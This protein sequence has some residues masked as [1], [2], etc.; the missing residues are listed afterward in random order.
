M[1]TPSLGEQEMELLHFMVQHEPMSV[2]DAV[3][4]FGA[5]R[6]L[7]RTTVL[8][9]MER[10]RKKGYLARND[11]GRVYLYSPSQPRKD[12]LARAVKGFVDKALGGSVS[13]IVAYLSREAQLS[14][15]DLEELRKLVHELE[16]KERD[17]D[18]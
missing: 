10:L 12:V 13:P 2:R 9:M 1:R 6:H 4:L 8:T 3:R 18:A 5:P 7:A 16:S 17:G 14:D 11:D 15:A